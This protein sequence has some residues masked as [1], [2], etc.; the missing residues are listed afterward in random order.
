M[1]ILHLVKGIVDI[2]DIS[3][4]MLDYLYMKLN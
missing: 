3:D 1:S 2:H 4:V